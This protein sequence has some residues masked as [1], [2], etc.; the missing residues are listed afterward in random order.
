MTDSD[1]LKGT[2]K[3]RN[4]RCSSCGGLKE[5]KDQGYCAKCHKDYMRDVYRPAKRQ[6]VESL[7]EEVD[8]LRKQQE[9]FTGNVSLTPRT[10][11][12]A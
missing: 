7:R 11:A 1:I 10:K 4:D 6:E 5:R 12:V 3:G 2:K 9:S 8:R